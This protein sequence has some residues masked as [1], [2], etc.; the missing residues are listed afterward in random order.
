MA[1]AVRFS[2]AAITAVDA[3]SL[4][5]FR[6]NWSSSAVQ[7]LLGYLAILG[8]R[9][10][11]FPFAFSPLQEVLDCMESQQVG[12]VAASTQK[13][14]GNEDRNVAASHAGFPSG[15]LTSSNDGGGG[16]H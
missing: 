11:H 2:F 8:A 4:A 10:I 16:R 14:D 1:V 6:S 3:L 12:T 13:R 7:R 15:R 5:S 9:S